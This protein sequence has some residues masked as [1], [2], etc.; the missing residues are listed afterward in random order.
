MKPEIRE[1]CRYEQEIIRNLEEASI[2]D[3]EFMNDEGSLGV[4]EIRPS[5]DWYQPDREIEYPLS[6]VVNWKP[7][8]R[9][10]QTMARI[11]GEY[12]SGD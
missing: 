12:K 5:P 8:L 7:Y 9:Y 3:L 2:E 1:G 10:R 6:W 4:Y 11:K